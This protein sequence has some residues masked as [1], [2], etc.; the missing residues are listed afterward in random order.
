MSDDSDSSSDSGWDAL[1]SAPVE[2]E[3]R[4]A[5]LEPRHAA[6]HMRMRGV[7]A[8]SIVVKAEIERAVLEAA[9]L[10]TGA[11]DTRLVVANKDLK[12]ELWHVTRDKG[13]L[14]RE[15]DS[16]MRQIKEKVKRESRDVINKLAGAAQL[17]QQLSTD[18]QRANNNSKYFRRQTYKLEEENK[19]LR[20][21]LK[22]INEKYKLTVRGSTR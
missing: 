13:T 1:E 7:S 17:S 10:H 5:E 21:M 15:C 11:D 19:E 14:Q 4:V 22:D 2:L 20:V 16:L 3:H 6:V 9:Q 18:I 8:T 12:K